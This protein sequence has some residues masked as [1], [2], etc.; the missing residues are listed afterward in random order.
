MINVHRRLELNLGKI[1]E[2]EFYEILNFSKKGGFSTSF[3]KL[4]Q[5]VFHNCRWNLGYWVLNLADIGEE[6]RIL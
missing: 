6:A 3:A 1:H 4:R 5:I 2:S